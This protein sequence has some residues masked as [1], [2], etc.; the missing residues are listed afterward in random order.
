M[1]WLVGGDSVK[2]F[3]LDSPV[4]GSFWPEL[5]D[6]VLATG[7]CGTG[8][9]NV[10]IEEKPNLLTGYHFIYMYDIDIDSS[11]S[12]NRKFK[13]LTSISLPFLRKKV[14][15][16]GLPWKVVNV[17]SAVK[18]LTMN[19]LDLHRRNVILAE[20]M[21]EDGLSGVKYVKRRKIWGNDYW[22][23]NAYIDN[24]SVRVAAKT[25]AKLYLKIK[26]RS[27]PWIIIDRDFYVNTLRKERV[28]L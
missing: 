7:D 8:Y 3:V 25:L 27:L 23:Y 17:D 6:N 14:L 10:Y 22:V 13:S 26:D 9:Y 4:N 20:K 2:P 1:K 28:Y 21:I 5:G 12:Q 18:A 15:K 11:S 19:S 24:K 16:K